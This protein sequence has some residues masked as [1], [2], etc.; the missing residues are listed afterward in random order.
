MKI[1]IVDYDSVLAMLAE[2][3]LLIAG[4]EVR[5]PV[6]Q[7]DQAL[8]MAADS[9]ADLALVNLD[10]QGS[11]DGIEVSRELEKQL[12]IPCILVSGC[13]R[14]ALDFQGA[15]TAILSKPFP[16]SDL[17]DSVRA[18][19]AIADGQLHD[20]IVWPSSLVIFPDGSPSS[21]K[22]PLNA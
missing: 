18:V 3:V 15:A 9:C 17:V 14:A 20:D 12:G 7:L 1:L 21:T 2:E 10:L 16:L 6:K 19:K 4:H 8:W 13:V 22:S 11:D 5:G